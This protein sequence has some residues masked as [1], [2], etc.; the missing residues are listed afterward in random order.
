MS[1]LFKVRLG[2]DRKR[3]DTMC[4]PAVV[5]TED[6][7]GC[8]RHGLTVRLNATAQFISALQGSWS[9]FVLD[10]FCWADEMTTQTLE[11]CWYGNT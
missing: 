1:K 4:N 8:V 7:D 2:F 10:L 6:N 5:K 9:E 11:F 3:K